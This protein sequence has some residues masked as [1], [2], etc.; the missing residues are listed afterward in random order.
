MELSKKIDSAKQT[1]ISEI[2]KTFPDAIIKATDEKFE[3]ED[4]TPVCLY[5]DA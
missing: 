4:A 5:A 2:M 1:V 3:D